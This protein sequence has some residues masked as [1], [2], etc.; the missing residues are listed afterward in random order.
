ML[1][2]KR[3]M[4]IQF[5]VALLCCNISGFEYEKGSFW[6]CLDIKTRYIWENVRIITFDSDDI[7]FNLIFYLKGSKNYSSCFTVID[8]HWYYHKNP[9]LKDYK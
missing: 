8:N 3:I 4:I 5:L 1:T 7:G 2:L 9:E 6:R